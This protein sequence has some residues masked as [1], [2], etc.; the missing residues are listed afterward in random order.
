MQKA[1]TRLNL[2]IQSIKEQIVGIVEV[3]S[4][5]FLSTGVK[6]EAM[7]EQ[8][9]SLKQGWRVLLELYGHERTKA[10]EWM[11]SVLR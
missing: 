6:V 2:Y 8:L 5:E 9:D 3:E 10:E 11:E 4:T 7:S 1:V